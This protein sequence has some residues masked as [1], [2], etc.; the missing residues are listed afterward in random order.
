MFSQFQ[1][2]E[3]QSDTENASKSTG[4]A[5]RNKRSQSSAPPTDN[6]KK[7]AIEGMQ[8]ALKQMEEHDSFQ[9]FGNYVASELRKI[10]NPDLANKVQ[11]KI[12][13]F[14]LKCLDEIDEEAGPS[15]CSMQYDESRNSLVIS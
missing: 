8:R 7:V 13:S 4:V 6:Y 14:M 11:R 9:V 1:N 10:H 15:E 12:A 5:V 2:F 3:S